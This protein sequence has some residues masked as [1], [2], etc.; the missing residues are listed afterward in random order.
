LAIIKRTSRIIKNSGPQIHTCFLDEK[1]QKLP[2]HQNE[3]N[4][5]FAGGH[6]RRINP[7]GWHSNLWKP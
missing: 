2:E 1:R 3:E 7:I 6:K 5:V 4:H